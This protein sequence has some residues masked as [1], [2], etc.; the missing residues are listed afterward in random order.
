MRAI[1]IQKYGRLPKLT[2]CEIPQRLQGQVLLKMKY[3]PINPSDLFF[4][5][6]LYGVK[7]EGFPIMGFEGSGVI[8][9][10]DDA[11]LKGKQVS[12]LANLNNGT[13]AEYMVSN[14]NEILVWPDNANLTLQ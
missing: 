12:V 2:N 7:K 5:L 4:Y 8:E 14:K 13:Y 11:Q 10:C 6:G 3:A 1:H 9:E